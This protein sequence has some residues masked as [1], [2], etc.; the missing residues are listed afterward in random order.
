MTDNAE[1]PP[2]ATVDLSRRPEPT[3]TRPAGPLGGPSY[4][5]RGAIIDCQPGGYIC[6]LLLPGCPLHGHSFGAAG[7]IPYLVDL[8]LDHKRLPPWIKAARPAPGYLDP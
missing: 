3:P 5:H 1:L 4:E 7:T 2:L 8:W 6:R